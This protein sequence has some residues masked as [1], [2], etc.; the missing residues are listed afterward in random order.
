MLVICLVLF[1]CMAVHRVFPVSTLH[2]S[3][4]L[5]CLSA[6]V[7]PASGGCGQRGGGRHRGCV[8]PRGGHGAEGEG[9]RHRVE[10]ARARADA[11]RHAAVRGVRKV[12]A[13]HDALNARCTPMLY[14]CSVETY[15]YMRCA[16]LCCMYTYTYPIV[17]VR[18]LWYS[19]HTGRAVCMPGSLPLFLRLL[20]VGLTVGP[21][22]IGHWPLPPANAVI[23]L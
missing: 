13:S 18:G 19:A 23:P 8:W 2:S 10:L 6:P 1:I 17:R 14:P 22:G 3:S 20:S 7:L 15:L 5:C 4:E 16:V 12:R 21:S 11:G 9:G